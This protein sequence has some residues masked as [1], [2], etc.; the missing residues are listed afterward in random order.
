MAVAL[1]LTCYT[2]CV[3]M[4]V[5]RCQ[6]SRRVLVCQLQ[7]HLQLTVSAPRERSQVE[8]SIVYTLPTTITGHTC[9]GTSPLAFIS[10][11]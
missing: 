5:Y 2:V 4:L 3:R 1:L 9:I 8:A 11:T 10:A 7:H 6:P